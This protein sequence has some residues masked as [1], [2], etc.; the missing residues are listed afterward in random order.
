MKKKDFGCVDIT[1]GTSYE[2][3]IPYVYLGTI[4]VAPILLTIYGNQSTKKQGKSSHITPVLNFDNG[5]QVD[6]NL[7]YMGLDS[8]LPVFCWDDIYERVAIGCKWLVIDG[9]ICMCIMKHFYFIFNYKLC[10]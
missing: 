7:K 5:E 3:I 4:G 1:A 10:R 6:K 2:H 9:V 8:I